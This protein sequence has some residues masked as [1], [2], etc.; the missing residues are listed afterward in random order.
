MAEFRYSSVTW[1]L[2]IPDACP[3]EKP[4]FTEVFPATFD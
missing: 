4:P 3:L 1:Q 2:G